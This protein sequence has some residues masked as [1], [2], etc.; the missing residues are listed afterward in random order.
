[1]YYEAED[2]IVIAEN[3]KIFLCGKAKVNYEKMELSA[4]VITVQMDSSMLHAY[5]VPDSTG[6][7]QGTPVFKD[8]DMPYQWY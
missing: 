7:K 5:G 1:M 6:V 8:N 2:S 3:G 4:Q